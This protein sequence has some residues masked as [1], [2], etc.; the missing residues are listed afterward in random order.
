MIRFKS[1]ILCLIVTSLVFIGCARQV[2]DSKLDTEVARKTDEVTPSVPDSMPGAM[3][4]E[5]ELDEPVEWSVRDR[6]LAF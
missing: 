5:M 1:L 6:A 2:S 4:E 3:V